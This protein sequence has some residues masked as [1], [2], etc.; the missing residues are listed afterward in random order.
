M[1]YIIN[2]SVFYWMNVADGLKEIFYFLLV[3]SSIS[4]SAGFIILA[5]DLTSNDNEKRNW[6]IALRIAVIVSAVSILGV[7]FV[8]TKQALMEMLIAKTATVENAEWTVESLKSVVDYI[9]QAA[10][11]LK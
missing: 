2:P 4:L 10:Q 1:N 7:L 8:P 11:S 5:N 9:V 6:R 3:I